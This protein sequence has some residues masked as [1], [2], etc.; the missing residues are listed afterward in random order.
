ML[1]GTINESPKAIF[2]ICIVFVQAT[3][4]IVVQPR[5]PGLGNIGSAAQHMAIA[6]QGQ[7]AF[8]AFKG[9]L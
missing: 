6:A 1:F 2:I 4:N 5:W 9:E 7:H 3:Q 8:E